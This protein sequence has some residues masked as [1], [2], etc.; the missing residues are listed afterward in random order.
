[1]WFHGWWTNGENWPADPAAARAWAQKKGYSQFTQVGHVGTTA[2]QFQAE[3][4][5]TKTPYIRVFQHDGYYYACLTTRHA[6][7]D[8][9]IR[10]R[11][12]SSVPIPFATVRMRA[13][14]AMSR[15]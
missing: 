2:L 5:I 4:S 3:P 6:C 11:V 8:R 9:K 12:S 1:M 13:G 7:R 10:S 14:F 15:S